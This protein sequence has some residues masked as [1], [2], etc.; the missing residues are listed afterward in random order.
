[1]E[2]HIDGEAK[3][4]S[5]YVFCPGSQ[6]RARKIAEYFENQVT[7][8]DNRGIV[9][10]SGIYEGVFMTS[11][12]TGMGGPAIAIAVE[13]LGHLGANTFIRVGSCGVLQPGQQVGD[14][15]IATGT[16]RAGGTGDNYLPLAFP[17]VPSFAVLRE[18]V[19]ASETLKIPA[20]V[21]VGY[22][23]DAF[24]GTNKSD[25]ID[26][27]KGAGGVFLEMESD[28]LFI[29]GAARGF[30][31]GALFTSDGAPGVIKPESGRED[32]Q[33]GEQSAIQ[34]AVKAMHAIAMRDMHDVKEPPEQKHLQSNESF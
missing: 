17:A 15:V 24:Y 10:Y 19:R 31:T 6:S 22:A 23:G 16:Y 29:I 27:V 13:E 25:L 5:K 33:K 32:F 28:T 7:V 2:F 12:G 30:R 26:I 1:M 3:D 20:K 34:I 11:C 14:V 18:L 21:G 8:S 9:V 4:I